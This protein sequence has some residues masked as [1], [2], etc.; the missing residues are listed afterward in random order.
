M[1]WK[2]PSIGPPIQD[3][4]KYTPYL[5]AFSAVAIIMGIEF[6]SLLSD[7]ARCV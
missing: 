3:V 7:S 6:I 5:P 4:K 1:V 2:S